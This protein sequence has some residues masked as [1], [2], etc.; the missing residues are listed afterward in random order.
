MSEATTT[1]QAIAFAIPLLPDK[2]DT[3]RSAM[4]SCWH[5]DRR[6]AYEAS[7]GRLGITREAVWIQSTPNG[8]VA[9]V[10]LEADDLQR[11][12]TGMGASNHPF[13]RWFRAH[14]LEVHGLDLTAGFPPPEQVLH[15]RSRET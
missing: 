15:F 7:R 2:T 13:D 1:G 12:F 4:L 11:A 6:T 10:H 5:G 9:V 3:D 8:D 14:C